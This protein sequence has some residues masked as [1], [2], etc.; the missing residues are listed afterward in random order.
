MTRIGLVS[1][2]LTV[3]LAL[4]CAKPRLESHMYFDQALDFSSIKT[5]AIVPGDGGTEANRALAERELSQ[6]FEAKGLRAAPADSADTLVQVDLGRRSKTR[7]SGGMTTGEYAGL[8]VSMR[9]RKSGAMAWHAVAR[10]TYYDSL[11]AANEIPK[12]VALLL[13]DFPPS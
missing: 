6:G 2:L 3:G 5:F 1:T 7:I 13:E 11:V 10:M 8:A 9:L 12:A 4:G